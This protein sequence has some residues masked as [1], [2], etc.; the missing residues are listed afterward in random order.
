MNEIKNRFYF[1]SNEL[2]Q[3]DIFEWNIENWNGLIPEKKSEL[4]NLCG[5]NW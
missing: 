5:L 2:L 4:F 1:Q 3:E